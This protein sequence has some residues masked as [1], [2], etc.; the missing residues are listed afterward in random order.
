[1][2]ETCSSYNENKKNKEDVLFK[3]FLKRLKAF[4]VKS[5]LKNW[6]LKRRSSLERAE[7][8]ETSWN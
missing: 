2:N 8:S 4:K 5:T 3:P 6:S 1:M 7:T